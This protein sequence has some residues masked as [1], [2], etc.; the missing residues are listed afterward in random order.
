MFYMRHETVLRHTDDP[1]TS[2]KEKETG[3]CQENVSQVRKHVLLTINPWLI[4]TALP[5]YSLHPSD[6]AW[7]LCGG[8]V[9][10]KKKVVTHEKKKTERERENDRTRAKNALLVNPTASRAHALIHIQAVLK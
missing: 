10:D 5:S 8:R 7:H 4:R 2:Q 3:S 6:G 9:E 1:H